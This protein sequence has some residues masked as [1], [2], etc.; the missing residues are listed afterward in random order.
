MSEKWKIKLNIHSILSQE[1]E[2]DETA[3]KIANELAD[4]LEIELKKANID[5]CKEII[6]ELRISQHE[7]E[8]NDALQNLYDWADEERIWLGIFE[9]NE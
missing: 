7:Y 4:Y 8:V 1:D 6:E 2:T 9:D 5:S 3:V